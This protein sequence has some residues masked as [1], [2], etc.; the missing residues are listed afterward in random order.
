MPAVIVEA[1]IP[2]QAIELYRRHGVTMAG[3]ATAFYQMF[4]AAQRAQPDQPIIPTLRAL[5]GGGAAC[6]PELFREVKAEMGMLS[7]SRRR[8]IFIRPRVSSLRSMATGRNGWRRLKA[9]S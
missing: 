5:S 8:N 4:L 2:D 7:G 9:K 1:F 6:P 3:G